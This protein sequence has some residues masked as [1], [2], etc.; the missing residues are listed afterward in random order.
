[1]RM[2]IIFV[3]YSNKPSI[4]NNNLKWNERTLTLQFSERLISSME[5]I[6]EET[7]IAKLSEDRFPH[8]DTDTHCIKKSNHSV[9]RLTN[10]QNTSKK[11][12]SASICYK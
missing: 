2:P 12:L 3:A 10:C 8:E 1:M 9:E 4:L 11:L 7:Y 5:N 6:I